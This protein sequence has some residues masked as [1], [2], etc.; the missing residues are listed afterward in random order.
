M[1]LSS[2]ESMSHLQVHVTET[3]TFSAEGSTLRGEPST[4]VGQAATPP[5]RRIWRD[6]SCAARLTDPSIPP[7]WGGPSVVPVMTG[8]AGAG[9]PPR[10][11]FPRATPGCPP[12]FLLGMGD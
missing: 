12:F 8:K 10:L 2:A 11:G 7:H 4:F 1:T 6:A 9:T 5:T 3:D